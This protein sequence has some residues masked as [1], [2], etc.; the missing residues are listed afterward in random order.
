MNVVRKMPVIGGLFLS[1]LSGRRSP[2]S[3]ISFTRSRYWCSSWLTEELEP[4]EGFS[5]EG[6]CE[7]VILARIVINC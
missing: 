7:A 4:L 5:A 6:V 3:R 2:V 1:Y